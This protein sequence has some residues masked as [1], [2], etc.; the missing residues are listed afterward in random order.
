MTSFEAIAWWRAPAIRKAISIS[1]F[2]ARMDEIEQ[3]NAAMASMLS[4]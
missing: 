1:L 3:E 2:K 4:G